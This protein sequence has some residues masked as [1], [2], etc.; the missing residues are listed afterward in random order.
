MSNKKSTLEDALSDL[1]KRLGFEMLRA[2]EQ[3][4]EARQSLALHHEQ[5]TKDG[6]AILKQAK[7]IQ[8]AIEPALSGKQPMDRKAARACLKY[9]SL[10]ARLHKIRAARIIGYGATL[11]SGE[12]DVGRPLGVRAQPAD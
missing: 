9:I 7:R 2:C 8:S 1:D 3:Y 10:M 5:M 11:P 6:E 4:R 12:Q